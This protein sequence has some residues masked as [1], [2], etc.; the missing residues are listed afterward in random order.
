VIAKLEAMSPNPIH[1]QYDNGE[2]HR[3]ES[4]VGGPFLQ[5]ASGGRAGVVCTLGTKSSLQRN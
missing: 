3:L 4:Y 5:R 2:I 1:V